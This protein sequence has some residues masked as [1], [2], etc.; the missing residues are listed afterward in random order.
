MIPTMKGYTADDEYLI[1]Q[2]KADAHYTTAT[3]SWGNLFAAR[4]QWRNERE[5]NREKHLH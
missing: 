3:G 5:Q 2:A 1:G 4:L